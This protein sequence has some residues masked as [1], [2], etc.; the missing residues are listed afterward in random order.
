MLL[1][2]ETQ[3]IV[4]IDT[5]THGMVEVRS[6]ASGVVARGVWVSEIVKESERETDQ[7]NVLRCVRR[8]QGTFCGPEAH[9]HKWLVK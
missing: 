9:T 4:R 1:L 8:V 3:L 5:R 2:L 6:D 7:R